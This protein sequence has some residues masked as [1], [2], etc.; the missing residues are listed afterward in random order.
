MG[1]TTTL[2]ATIVGVCLGRLHYGSITG[3]I[4]PFVVLAQAVVV[5]LA[6]YVRDVLGSYI[7]ARRSWPSRLRISWLSR[8]LRGSIRRP[9][10]RGICDVTGSG[11]AGL[12]Y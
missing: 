10:R 1:G 4:V 2:Q 12:L 6:G 3:R 7:P 5:P 8:A 9:I 11:A